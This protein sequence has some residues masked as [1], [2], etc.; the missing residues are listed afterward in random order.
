MRFVYTK[1]FLKGLKSLQKR[2][3]AAVRAALALFADDPFA[4]ALRN[5]PLKGEYKGIRSIDAGFDLRI[6]FKEEGGY[7]LVYLVQ[8]GSHAKLY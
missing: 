3:V 7:V 1:A 8:V 4:P 5:H 6:L 2:D